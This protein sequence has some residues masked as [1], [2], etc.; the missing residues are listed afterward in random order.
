MHKTGIKCSRYLHFWSW[1]RSHGLAYK[2]YTTIPVCAHAHAHAQGL[3]R[4]ARGRVWSAD[5]SSGRVLLRRLPVL[6]QVV[7]EAAA[8]MFSTDADTISQRGKPL[9]S[10]RFDAPSAVVDEP[11]QRLRHL[12]A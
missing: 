3:H 10:K 7:E 6:S 4:A 1:A 8:R 11:P 5:E 12:H 2:I 9:V